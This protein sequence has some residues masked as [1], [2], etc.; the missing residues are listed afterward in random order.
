MPLDVFWDFS[1]TW[2]AAYYVNEQL[3]WPFVTGDAFT[4]RNVFQLLFQKQSIFRYQNMKVQFW[5]VG[6]YFIYYLDA[7]DSATMPDSTMRISTIIDATL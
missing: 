4:S 3:S 5:N 7:G 6:L 2:L 1:T